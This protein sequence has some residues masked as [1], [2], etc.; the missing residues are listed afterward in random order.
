M[1][2]R[3]HFFVVLA[4]AVCGRAVAEV[5]ATAP[6]TSPSLPGAATFSEQLQ[7][8]ANTAAGVCGIAIRD[9]KGG[10]EFFVRGDQLFSQAG[11]SKIHVLAALLRESSAGRIDLG[12]PHTLAEEEKLPGGILQR[13]GAGT[14]TMS[15]RDYAT[16]MVAVDDNTAASIL[17]KRI[18]LPA[19]RDTLAALG[20]QDVHFAGL[21]TDPA[22][23]EDNTASPRGILHCLVALH[24][25]PLLDS[26]ARTELFDLLSTPRQGAIRAGVPR[27]VKVASKS[28]IRGP[29]R[30][31]AAIVFHK[32]RP[33]AIVVMTQ[34]PKSDDANVLNEA[35]RLITE[36]SKLAYDH[37][38][39]LEAPAVARP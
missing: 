31:S 6:S 38:S 15:L 21:I 10:E 14:V 26:K 30:N 39:R 17:L 35:T 19:V 29:L 16:L 23:P 11:L 36:I 28:G 13:L 32:N 3:L 22:K 12:T 25:G 8:L 37:F 9:L 24:K 20:A 1:F 5:P 18:G 4:I 2:R 34:W 7:A 27:D 33:Y